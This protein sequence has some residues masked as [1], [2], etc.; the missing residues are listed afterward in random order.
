MIPAL[1]HLYNI[2]SHIFYTAIHKYNMTVIGHILMIVATGAQCATSYYNRKSFQWKPEFQ[3][4]HIVPDIYL[5]PAN[6]NI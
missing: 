3:K 6:I 1:T 2:L 5:L 4:V